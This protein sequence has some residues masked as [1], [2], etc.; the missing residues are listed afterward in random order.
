MYDKNN[1]VIQMSKLYNKYLELKQTN[2]EIIYLFKSGIFFISL[3]QDAHASSNIFGFKLSNFTP[4]VVKCG[5]P[6]SSIEKYKRLFEA[7]NLNF[8]II[9]LENANL[10]GSFQNLEIIE[11]LNS[12]KNI[13]INNLSI[14]EAY[15]L[16]EKLQK[17]TEKIVF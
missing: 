8:K 13:D 7:C 1:M 10:K 6:C 4:T 16:I 11:L 15:A 17:D 9:E 14:K 2:P 5:F 12:I 3:A